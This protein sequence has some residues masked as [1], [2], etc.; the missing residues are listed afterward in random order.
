MCN[1]ISRCFLHYFQIFIFGVNSG[2][3]KTKN[4]LKWQKNY[5]GHTPY[6]SKHTSLDHIFCCTSLKWWHCQMLFW[7]FSKFW[8]SGLLGR[9][10]VKGKK[11]PKMT[12]KKLSYS[13]SQEVYI[14][15]WS[16]ELLM[17]FKIKISDVLI[18][19][20]DRSL[21]RILFVF[22]FCAMT[23]QHLQLLNT[24]CVYLSYK[25]VSWGTPV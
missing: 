12:K 21:S 5:V 13:I 10:R 4:C 15:A 2:V 23:Q 22:G 17:W 7:F 6:L 1:K 8:F 3:N 14:F 19:L 24:S 16:N 20:W 11:W 9:K 18:L 25:K